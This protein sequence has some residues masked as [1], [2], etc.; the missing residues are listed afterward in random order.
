MDRKTRQTY[1]TIYEWA[2]K[3]ERPGGEFDWF[4]VDSDGHLAAFATA[5]FGPVPDSFFS[6]G[7]NSYLNLVGLVDDKLKG[8]RPVHSGGFLPYSERGFYAYDFRTTGSGQ[9]E[10]AAIPSTPLR[11]PDAVVLGF[12][13]DMFV[14][15]A[16]K[17]SESKEVIP[18]VF[19]NCR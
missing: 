10:I 9:Y 18:E 15:F 4:A 5:G 14:E 6:L 2:E 12:S 17:F 1:Q 16:G 3:A 11:L 19:W 13:Q 7:L 8:T